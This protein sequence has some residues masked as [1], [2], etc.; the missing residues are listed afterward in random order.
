MKPQ[1]L[2]IILTAINLALLVFLLAQVIRPENSI[3][4]APVLRTR[5]LE[6]VDD[7]GRVRAQILVTPPT[8]MDGKTYPDTALFRLIDPNGRPGVKIGTSVDGSGLLLTGDSERRE[9]TGVQ[10]LAEGSGSVVKLLNRDGREQ[11]IQP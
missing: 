7:Q 6:I 10:I 3:T 1:R 8:A 5:L 4:V 11:L 9:W 2:T